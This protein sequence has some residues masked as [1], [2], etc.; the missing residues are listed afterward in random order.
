MGFPGGLVLKNPPG[1]A[2]R[3]KSWGFSPWVGK[4]PWRRKRQ[5]APV[6]LPE[7]SRGQRSLVDTIRS[8]RVGHTEGM[9]VLTV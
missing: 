9:S 7:K 2:K 8:Q 4:I 1:N 5:L 6:F 3:H